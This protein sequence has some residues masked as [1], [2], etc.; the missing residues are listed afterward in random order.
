M[1]LDP[2]TEVGLGMLVP[3]LVGG[4][5]YVVDLQGG[6]KRPQGQQHE[7]QAER[8]QASGGSWG[9]TSWQETAHRPVL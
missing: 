7:R 5:E 6:R 8:Q 9:S 2:L 4:G 1:V 3:V